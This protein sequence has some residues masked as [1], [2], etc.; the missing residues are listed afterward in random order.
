MFFLNRTCDCNWITCDRNSPSCDCNLLKY[1]WQV[2][3][4]SNHRKL[5][6]CDCKFVRCD[7]L[8]TRLRSQVSTLRPTRPNR[9]P[10]LLPV[11]RPTDEWKSYF[12]VLS[13]LRFDISGCSAFEQYSGTKPRDTSYRFLC[14]LL[15]LVLGA[16]CLLE[17]NMIQCGILSALYTARK[18]TR[19]QS[20]MRWVWK[21]RISCDEVDKHRDNLPH[22]IFSSLQCY[23]V[24]WPVFNCVDDV[25]T[26]RQ[27][28][29]DFG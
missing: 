9:S 18:S 10:S 15:F 24:K 25:S 3:N 12:M 8:V 5:R 28:L 21:P 16:S 22:I 26:W 27:S 4:I 6:S 2:T 7:R 29:D 19:K 14:F 11:Q 20:D 17:L 13:N 1:R 23:D